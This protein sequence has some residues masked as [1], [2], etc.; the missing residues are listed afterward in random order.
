MWPATDASSP[1]W[2]SWNEYGK[3]RFL[4]SS[5]M[6]G[7]GIKIKFYSTRRDCLKVIMV[8]FVILSVTKD[9]NLAKE[10]VSLRSMTK[11]K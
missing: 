2:D 9:L 1:N 5:L 11:R 7:R 10:D 8:S 3:Q 4:N 6:N